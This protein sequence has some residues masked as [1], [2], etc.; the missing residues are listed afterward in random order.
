MDT[1]VFL[2]TTPEM[3]IEKLVNPTARVYIDKGLWNSGFEIMF[4]KH[5][6]KEKEE[7]EISIGLEES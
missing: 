6:E 3:S 5:Y 4:R 2:L 7:Q 1:A